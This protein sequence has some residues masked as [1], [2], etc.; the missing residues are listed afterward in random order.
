MC[1]DGDAEIDDELGSIGQHQTNVAKD[2]KNLLLIRVLAKIY[3][4][5][6]SA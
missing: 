3:T 5:G 4:I 6:S 1:K 2:L